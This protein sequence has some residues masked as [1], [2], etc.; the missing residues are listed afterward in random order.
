MCSS[1]VSTVTWVSLHS[2]R[3]APVFRGHDLGTKTG[4][5]EKRAQVRRELLR[6]TNLREGTFVLSYVYIYT[7]THSLSHSHGLA[8]TWLH[9][10]FDPHWPLLGR[11]RSVAA[12]EKLKATGSH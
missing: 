11:L 6:A 3:G 7:H 10:E 9:L 8:H 1:L 12:V 5:E 4:W 2:S